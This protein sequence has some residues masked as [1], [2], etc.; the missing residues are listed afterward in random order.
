MSAFKILVNL[1]K[2]RFRINEVYCMSFVSANRI[3]YMVSMYLCDMR[4]SQ[5]V[6]VLM[7]QEP[8][9]SSLGT[10]YAASKVEAGANCGASFH[11][12]LSALIFMLAEEGAPSAGSREPGAPS[13]TGRTSSL[14]GDSLAWGSATL[15]RL[16]KQVHRPV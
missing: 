6:H 14:L 13:P 16:L 12:V 10:L 1:E 8:A 5:Q 7:C 9:F 11:N 2:V 3:I 15:L 4:S